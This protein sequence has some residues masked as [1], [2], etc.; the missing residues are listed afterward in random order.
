MSQLPSPIPSALLRQ[1]AIRAT[2]VHP[3]GTFIE[4]AA[5]A[6][7]QSI[8]ARF[9]QQVAHHPGRLAVKSKH[10]T[11]TYAAL[12]SL[13]NRVAGAI[14]AQQKEGHA[15]IGLMCD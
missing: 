15:P 4:F 12:N 1:Q 6:I 7:E 10:Q 2:C 5:E 9:E 8:P 14:L 3:T 13:A 11:L